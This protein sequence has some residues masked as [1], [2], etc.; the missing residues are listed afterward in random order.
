[1]M[2][3]ADTGLRRVRKTSASAGEETGSQRQD[4]FIGQ[5]KKQSFDRPMLKP[6]Q[7]LRNPK[8]GPGRWA[9]PLSGL[10]LGAGN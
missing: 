5:Q 6:S 10:T 7:S 2:L 9:L 1:M 3:A 4:G 8:S